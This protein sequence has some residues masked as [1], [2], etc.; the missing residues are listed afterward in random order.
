MPIRRSASKIY[1]ISSQVGFSLSEYVIPVRRP[2]VNMLRQFVALRKC[3]TPV[4]RSFVNML[5]QLAESILKVPICNNNSQVPHQIYDTSSQACMEQL[6]FFNE[7]E[8]FFMC[9]PLSLLT[10]LT[11]L[12]PTKW[13]PKRVSITASATCS[14]GRPQ[15]LRGSIPSRVETSKRPHH[16]LPSH[17]QRRRME[18]EGSCGHSHS[19]D[20][21][22]QQG[23]PSMLGSP[24][25]C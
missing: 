22:R 7:I 24:Q 5:R 1:Y 25:T 20:T 15:N 10:F 13:G 11:P 6:I 9:Y 16:P 18:Q 19:I 3:I 21:T 4:R 2:F 23:S 8:P 12:T 17:R 14:H